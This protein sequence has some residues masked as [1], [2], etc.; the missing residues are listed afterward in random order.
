MKTIVNLGVLILALGMTSAAPAQDITAQE[1]MQLDSLRAQFKS[2]GIDLKPEDEVRMLQRIRALN[3]AGGNTGAGAGKPQSPTINP[4][5]QQQIMQAQQRQSAAQVGNPV[6][7]APTTTAQPS[8]DQLR[9]RL[10]S[11]PAPR[12]VA[13]IE[14]LPDGL[15]YDGQ[16]FADPEGRA[17]R[18]TVDAETATAAYIVQTAQGA[19]V[20]IARLGGGAEPITIGRL[21]TE[22]R[23]QVFYSSTGKTLAGEMFF[24]LTDGVLIMRESVGFRYV[25]GA[26]VHQVDIPQGWYPTPIQRG[27]VATTGQLLLERD[28]AEDKANP[29]QFFKKL[30]QLTGQVE[31]PPDYALFNMADGRLTPFDISAAGKSVTTLSQ[32]HRRNAV[33]N[34]C[35][36]SK[37]FESVWEKDG[38]PNYGHY[39]W[40]VD[41]QRVQG[42]PIAVAQESGRKQIN[43]YDLVS[44]KKVN[45]FERTLGVTGFHTETAGSRLKVVYRV[46]FDSTTIDDVS[47]EIRA[48]PQMVAPAPAGQ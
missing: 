5:L 37:T 42:S 2:Q 36:Q 18:F 13:T 23:K 21:A 27:N 9:T 40:R 25:V 16:R 41:W 47:A 43:A 33:V 45:L 38:S 31:A 35:D 32:C 6:P 44:G 14:R 29:L 10:A 15:K 4:A 28:Q 3:A 12:A 1:M 7:V 11:L 46:G 20:K 26:G 22:G 24:P 48:R 17:E 39:Y 30:G 34:V 19:M 8:E